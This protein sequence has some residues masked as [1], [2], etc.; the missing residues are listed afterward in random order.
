MKQIPYLFYRIELEWHS[1]D[2][3]SFELAQGNVVFL[4]DNSSVRHMWTLPEQLDILS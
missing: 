2:S 3:Y 1:V 4:P